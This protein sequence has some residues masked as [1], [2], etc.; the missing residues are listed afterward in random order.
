MALRY[1]SLDGLR[2]VSILLVMIAHS[3]GSVG[4]S[5]A[6]SVTGLDIGNL[7]VRIFFVVS[8]FLITNLLLCE[9][10]QTRSI[11]IRNFY[12]RRFFRIFPAFYGYLGVLLVLAIFRLIQLPGLTILRSALYLGDYPLLTAGLPSPYETW[13]TV[14]TWSLAVEEQFYLMWPLLLLTLRPS[15][16]IKAVLVS[17]LAQ[18][19]VRLA[20]FELFPSYRPSLAIS[21]EMVSD[22]LATGCLLA[23]ARTSLHAWAPYNRLLGSRFIVPLAVSLLWLAYRIKSTH[24]FLWFVAAIPLANFSAAFLIDHCIT[25]ENIYTK[26]LNLTWV[27]Y[28]GVLSYSLYLWQEVFLVQGRWKSEPWHW[29]P[30]SWMLAFGAASGS[31]YLVERPFLRLRERLRILR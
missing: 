20:I 14:H 8:G 4:A 16:A 19:F 22:A 26:A 21:F 25:A 11:S 3:R 1:K 18:P 2:A 13:F 17:I 29:F 5:W 24:E 27:A 31:Y 15:G 23:L 28:I 7:G 30:I 10:S 9:L 6:R 12:I